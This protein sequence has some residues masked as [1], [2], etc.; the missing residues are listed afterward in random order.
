MNEPVYDGKPRW[1]DGEFEY[2]EEPQSPNTRDSALPALADAPLHLPVGI[3]GGKNN[4]ADSVQKDV[5]VEYEFK[6][7]L[8]KFNSHNFLL[9][10]TSEV[11]KL[12]RALESI[13]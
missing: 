12:T 10:R 4:K 9:K 13:S 8:F 11:E 7:D 2:D 6:D 1:D 3:A 5:C